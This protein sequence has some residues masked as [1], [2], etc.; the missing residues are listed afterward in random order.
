MWAMSWKLQRGLL[1]LPVLAPLL[2][3]AACGG[4]GEGGGEPPPPPA[5]LQVAVPGL[6][7]VKLSALGESWVALA[8]QS[9]RPSNNTRPRRQLLLSVDGAAAQ[10][11]DGLVPE[12]WSLLDLS[13]HPSRQISVLLGND[14]QLRLLRLSRQGGLLHQQDFVDPQAPLDPFVGNETV[15]RDSQS[16]LPYNTRDAARLAA[17]GED[18]VLGLRTGRHAV[19]LHQLG[20]SAAAGF[21]KQ[22]RSLVEP[23]VH[24]GTRGLFS[25]SFDPFKALDHQ[26]RLLL[27]ADAQGRIAVAVSLMDTD[28]IEGHGQHFGETLDPTAAYGLLLSQ[29]SASG[30]RLGTLLINTRQRSEPHALRWVG[31]RIAVAGRVRSQQTAEGWDAYLALVPA[32]SQALAAYRVLDFEQGDIIF[33][34]APLADGRM[35]VSGSSGY[36]QN[37][38]GASVSEA[39]APLLALLASDGTLIRRVSV[40]AGPRHNQLRSLAPWGQGYL[41]GGMVNGPGT[42]SA[43]ADLNL[44][45][46]DGWV[47]ER[48]DLGL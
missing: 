31:D 38:M 26:W 21:Q 17:V 41:L 9:E 36:T 12:G 18:L 20:Y 10:R 29:F 11:L 47:A 2:F 23:G 40:A 14:H 8:E 6:A 33:D 3:L 32:G 16:L 15:I 45:K 37:P 4:G 5:P 42:H 39:A 34:I 24:I 27:D 30:Q 25:G 13:L 35:L 22:W 46:A 28:L 1:I 48:R 43:D 7:V 19:L 44:L